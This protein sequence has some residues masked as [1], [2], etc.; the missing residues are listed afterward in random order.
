M[1]YF[2]QKYLRD[3]IEIIYSQMDIKKYYIYIYNDKP[4]L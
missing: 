4:R 2:R 3:K 1:I